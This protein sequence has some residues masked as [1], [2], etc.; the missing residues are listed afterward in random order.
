MAERPAEKNRK[1]GNPA[2][3]LSGRKNILVLTHKNADLDAFASAVIVSDAFEGRIV[4]PGGAG[5]PAKEAA[6]K[7]GIEILSEIPE[8]SFSATVVVDCSSESQ[9]EPLLASALP[10]PLVVF[11]H[12]LPK[13]GEG[14][15]LEIAEGYFVDEQ[16]SCVEVVLGF[17]PVLSK[18]SRTAAISGIYADTRHLALARVGTLQKIIELSLGEEDLLSEGK[19]LASGRPEFSQRFAV[20][21]SLQKLR[22]ERLEDET[23]LATTVAGSFESVAAGMLVS[24]GAD[25]SLVAVAKEGEVR[26]SGRTSNKMK[27]RLHLGQLFQKLGGGGHP[28]AALANI[29]VKSKRPSDSDVENALSS[30]ANLIKDFLGS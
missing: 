12:H 28:G 22:F 3:I 16:P 13:E 15:L 19:N 17:F 21:K 8:G 26:I 25:I 29:P 5:K 18:R 10:K 6:E 23:I 4:A 2:K 24:A 20:I 1:K 27:D 7:L 30:A 14:S 9:I 11:D